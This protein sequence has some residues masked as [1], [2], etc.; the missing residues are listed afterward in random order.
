MLFLL[1]KN[2]T[3]FLEYVKNKNKK[4][5]VLIVGSAR[6]PECCPDE[7]SKTHKLAEKIQEDF[8]DKV[9]FDVI[10]LSVKCDGVNVQPCK[11]C[12]STSCFHCHWPCDCYSK[13]SDPKDL[14]HEQKVYNK[15]EN[16]DGFF[17]ITP[18]NW[19]AATSVVKS[20]FDRLVCANLTVTV[21]EAIGILGKDNLKNSKKTRKA[22]SSGEHLKL[23]KNHLEGKYAGFFGHGNNGGS[24]YKNFSKSKS[25]L[26]PVIPD[27][28]VEF[29]KSNPKEDTSKLLDPL[30]RQCVY[31]GI[32]VPKDCVKCVVFGYG[33]SYSEVNDM[34]DEKE[35]LF[36]MAGDTFKSFLK[37]I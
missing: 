23:L 16:C 13:E 30:V 1:N 10:D 3:N 24:D 4:K 29:E 7:K 36:K 22:E 34:M 26:L 2:M 5:V 18:I 21:D 31:S 27:S 20:F 32:H 8:N 37:Y 15:L 28:M 11:G 35:D 12:V 25:N 33:V 9:S 14:M 17:L 6:S 19:S